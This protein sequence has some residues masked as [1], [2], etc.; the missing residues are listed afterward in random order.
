MTF[1]PLISVGSGAVH[2]IKNQQHF[3]ITKQTTP[4]T[5]TIPARAHLDDVLLWV[6]DGRGWPV[7]PW[8]GVHGQVHQREAVHAVHATLHCHLEDVVPRCKLEGKG[9]A[10]TT[11]KATTIRSIL[12]TM[13]SQDQYCVG[14]MCTRLVTLHHSTR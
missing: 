2:A 5:R 6:D 7:L 9:H 4:I 10:I 1:Q 3:Q 13:L 12:S 11:V 8:L 14:G